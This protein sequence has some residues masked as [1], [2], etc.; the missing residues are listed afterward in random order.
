MLKKI[1]KIQPDLKVIMISANPDPDLEKKAKATGAFAFVSK[2]FNLKK[3]LAV[4]K[5][6]VGKK[7]IKN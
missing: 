7:L 2:P 6:A 3:L 1:F 5:K 4:I